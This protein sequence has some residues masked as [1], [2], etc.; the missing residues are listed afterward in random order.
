MKNVYKT[1]YITNSNMNLKVDAFIHPI[2]VFNII[3]ENENLKLSTKGKEKIIQLK[4]IEDAYIWLSKGLRPVGITQEVTYFMDY[5]I[6]ELNKEEIILEF[7]NYTNFKRFYNEMKDKGIVAKDEIE[8]LNVITDSSNPTQKKILFDRLRK[9][10]PKIE[11]NYGQI[12]KNRLKN[13][14]IGRF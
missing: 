2:P 14:Y 6:K 12:E 3:F 11:K 10:M 1:D 8:L 4:K 9:M 5:H 7:S 13:R